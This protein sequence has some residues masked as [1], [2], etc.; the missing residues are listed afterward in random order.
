MD[1]SAS[2]GRDRWP[3]LLP[4]DGVAGRV[5]LR[6]MRPDDLDRFH[7]YRSDA[8]T[9]RFQGWKQASD[10]AQSLAFLQEMSDAPIGVAGQWVQLAMAD[11]RDDR[12]IGDIGLC[13]R[14][15]PGL[16][17]ET[18]QPVLGAWMGITLHPAFRGQGLG[19]EGFV[20]LQDWLLQAGGLQE[21]ECWV[22]ARNT[23][24]IR[25]LE[26]CGMTRFCTEV[27]D[28]RGESCEEHGYRR[29]A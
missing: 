29:Q 13:V 14:E 6:R 9:A 26:A 15:L 21:I 23:A 24:S 17:A 28:F 3:A 18:G 10:P 8:D 11:R 12:L 16:A 4:L 1:S 19:R 27:R 25:L 22:D 7:A 2:P 5:Q 20:A